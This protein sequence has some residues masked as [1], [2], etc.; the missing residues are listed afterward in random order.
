MKKYKCLLCGKIID[1]DV[2]CPYC[3]AGPEYIVPLSEEELK[4]LDKKDK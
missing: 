2:R 3:G 1:T 4:E